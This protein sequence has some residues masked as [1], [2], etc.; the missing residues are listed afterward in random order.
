VGNEEMLVFI[1]ILYISGYVPVPRRPMF[2]EGR[3][4]TKNTLVSNS[5]RR[6]RFEDIFRYI[7]TAD[8]NNLPKNDKMAK[9]RPLI[10]KVNELFVGYTPVSEDMSIGESIIPYFGRNG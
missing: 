9:L 5:M 4:D 1:S 6:N 10:E 2:W 3:P 8:N 7:H